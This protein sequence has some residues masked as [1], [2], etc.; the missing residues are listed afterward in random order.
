MTG[1][2]CSSLARARRSHLAR[3]PADPANDIDLFA[4]AFIGLVERIVRDD[5]NPRRV[6]IGDMLQTLCDQPHAVMQHKD[7][8]RRRCA[9]TQIDQNDIAIVQG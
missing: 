3:E 4:A 7:A 9:P 8:R 1:R 2:R 5:A 6:A